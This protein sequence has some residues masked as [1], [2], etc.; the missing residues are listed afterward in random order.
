MGRR[1]A[2]LVADL[3]RAGLLPRDPVRIDAVDQTN[4][5]R[6]TLGQ[7]AHDL[8]A[9]VEVADNLDHPRTMHHALR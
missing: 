3:E 5:H 1:V 4:P 9:D 2:Q 8:Q 7:I 6:I